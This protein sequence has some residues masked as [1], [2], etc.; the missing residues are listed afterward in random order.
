MQSK[1]LSSRPSL[2]QYKKQ[3][4]DLLRA[5]RAAE[6]QAIRRIKE[7]HPLF[8][9]ATD[10]QLRNA[11]LLLADVQLIIAREH[12]REN[13]TSLKRDILA[14]RQEL[15]TP[16]LEK[17]ALKYMFIELYVSDC[18]T[19]AHFFE[20]ALGFERGYVYEESGHLDFAVMKQPVAK[21]EVLLHQMLPKEEAGLPRRMRLYFETVD[22]EAF[23]ASLRSK[24]YEISEPKRA[25]HGPL[26]A[27]LTG[28]D[29][30]PITIQQ[31]PPSTKS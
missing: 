23:C 5:S 18:E 27:T 14:S 31:W 16:V 25:S 24:G 12:G 3:A 6:P 4:N 7:H 20:D 11:K 13:W 8:V 19:A 15:A 2:E 26:M 28:P 1:P 17:T 10:T 30:Y 29:G 22:I 9:K 21:V